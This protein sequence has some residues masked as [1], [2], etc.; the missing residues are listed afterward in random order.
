MC[1]VRPKY[2]RCINP[3][4]SAQTALTMRK[5]RQPSYKFTF[6]S[7]VYMTSLFLNWSLLHIY[8]SEILVDTQAVYLEV[9]TAGQGTFELH[10]VKIEKKKHYI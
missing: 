5:N 7:Q 8:K 3:A 10:V 9:Y 2:Q 1:A 4:Q 6:F